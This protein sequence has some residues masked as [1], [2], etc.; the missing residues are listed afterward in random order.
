ML[1]DR[2]ELFVNAAK[3][4]NLAKTAREMHVTASS[5]CQR[6]RSLENDFGVK[7]YRRTKT[8]IE[9]TEAGETVVSTASDV[10]TR[11]ETLRERFR[12]KP[13]VQP[14]PLVIGGTYTPSAKYLPSA[15]AAFQ[16]SHPDVKV[17]FM[18]SI[19]AD[20]EKMLHDGQIE[21]AVIQSP[22]KSPDF[23][24]EPCAVD[25]LAFFAHPAHPLTKKK[26]LDYAALV[27]TPLVIREGGTTERTLEQLQ[28]RGF[29]MNV[30]LRCV[31]PD[32]VKAAVRRQTGLGILFS[33]LIEESVKN[34]EFKILNFPY[35]NVEAHS[36]IVYSK[37][38]PLSC[39]A[40]EF[41]TVLR[42]KKVPQQGST[43]TFPSEMIER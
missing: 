11:L 15:I 22:S 16:R 13:E 34:K 27:D 17:S 12:H 10:F 4:Q 9:L 42:S 3:H 40:N 30:T 37:K 38:Q 25:R 1:F 43:S 21:I 31:S 39:N 8:G 6:L 29:T 14:L 7:L 41:L 23:F 35:L 19:K 20:I 24:M 36:Y 33:S 2:I 32:A 28:S 18:T 5:V 26:I